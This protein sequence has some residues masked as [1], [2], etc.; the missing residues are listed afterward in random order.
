MRHL[1]IR[2]A[3]EGKAH[4]CIC[5]G[6]G[7]H[8]A[9]MYT[10]LN[11][12]MYACIAHDTQL[13]LLD[14]M[15]IWQE[16]ELTGA[17]LFSCSPH[18]YFFKALMAFLMHSIHIHPAALACTHLHPNLAFTG[19]STY[20]SAGDEAVPEVAEE[21]DELI[22]G[23]YTD[24]FSLA[25]ITPASA[26][27]NASAFILGSNTASEPA[28]PGTETG[29]HSIGISPASPVNPNWSCI[30]KPRSTLDGLS[31]VKGC[32]WFPRSS[33]RF[34]LDAEVLAIRH[35]LILTV[36]KASR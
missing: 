10:Q 3:P 29:I 28:P 13:A 9:Y 34:G 12:G 35:V 36:W 22:P 2:P 19:K 27:L 30:H 32:E 31:H 6:K 20:D 7:W 14:I 25:A 15:P 17:I 23:S 24:P 18:G 26:G 8:Q 5:H 11:V 33:S 21:V 1:S 16:F 4:A